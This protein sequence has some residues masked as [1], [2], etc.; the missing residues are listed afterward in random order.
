VKKEPKRLKRKINETN[1]DT[2]IDSINKLAKEY[3]PLGKVVTVLNSPA[4]QKE[5][6]ATLVPVDKTVLNYKGLQKA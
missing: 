2:R 1:R 4:M 6:I 3:R 5:L